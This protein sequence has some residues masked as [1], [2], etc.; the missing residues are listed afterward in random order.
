MVSFLPTLARAQRSIPVPTNAHPARIL[1]VDSDETAI[2]GFSS[3]LK[4]QGWQVC[5]ASD[6]S[7]ALSL[8]AAVRFDLLFAAVDSPD[9]DGIEL[10]RRIRQVN[11]DTPVVLI[12]DAPHVHTAISAV[13]HGANGYVPKLLAPDEL[14]QYASRLIGA[15][16]GQRCKSGG[17]KRGVTER[18][19]ARATARF[20]RALASLYMK[21]QPIVHLPELSVPAYEALVRTAEPSVPSPH[22]LFQLAESLGETQ[23]LGHVIRQRC[24]DAIPSAPPDS[25][26]FINLHADDLNDPSLLDTAGPLAHYARRIVFEIT[27]RAQ[28][29]DL[30]RASEPVRRLRSLGYRIAIDD[31]GGGYASLNSFALLEPDVAKI[32]M[33]LVRDIDS[34]RAKQSVIQALVRFCDGAG[35]DVVAEGVET[36][37]EFETLARLGCTLLQGFLFAVPDRRFLQAL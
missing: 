1:L 28:L 21:F 9:M 11:T 31:I 22:D 25:M 2:I 20:E 23:R 30:E 16:R 15:L 24:A 4:R 12:T 29:A 13:N 14:V 8:I 18:A 35:I 10:L 17:L 5:V 26:L 19:P 33:G 36:Q 32:D 3:A 37:A 6:D 34:S 27:E 7:A